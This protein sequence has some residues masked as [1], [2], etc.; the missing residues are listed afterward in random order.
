L[1]PTLA[2]KFPLPP[3][4]GRIRWPTGRGGMATAKKQRPPLANH[5][6]YEDGAEGMRG[7]VHRGERSMW[8]VDGMAQP[9]MLWSVEGSGPVTLPSRAG[10]EA[11]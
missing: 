3:R 8:L 4:R 5:A 10:G 11:M 1:P 7:D 6:G 9:G 2:S